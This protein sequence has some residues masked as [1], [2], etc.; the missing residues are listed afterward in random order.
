MINKELLEALKNVTVHLIAAYSLLQRAAL[1]AAEQNAVSEPVSEVWIVVK[2]HAWEHGD[3]GTPTLAYLLPSE[4]GRT[5]YPSFEAAS[6]FIRKG[7]W[8]LGFVAMKLDATPL[9]APLPLSDEQ[10]RALCEANSNAEADAF[11]AARPALDF[12]EMRR[13][14]YAGHR[15]AWISKDSLTKAAHNI[16]AKE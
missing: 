7:N 12:P 9:A 3:G 8:P 10:D 16:G 4:F 6:A 5:T 13:I 14:F 2:E 11:F 1:A 15:R